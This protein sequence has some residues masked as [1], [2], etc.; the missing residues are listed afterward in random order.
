MVRVVRVTEFGPPSVL[1]P[2]SRPTPSPGAGEALVEVAVAPVLLLDAQLRSGWGRES[3]PVTPPYVPG[4]GVAGH[5]SAVGDGVAASWAGRPA[6]ADT[7]FGGYASAAL[8]PASALVPVPPGVPLPEAAALLHDG[9]TAMRLLSV[10]PVRPGSRV[11]ITGA[12]GR[13]GCCW[14]NWRTRR[15]AR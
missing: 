10:H 2:G 15:V 3:F 14:C 5:V 6:V 7:V 1:V 11:L 4:M 12:A 13:W 9:R 8:V